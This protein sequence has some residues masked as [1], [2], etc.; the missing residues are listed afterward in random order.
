MVIL[1]TGTSS[2][3]GQGLAEALSNEHSVIPL[4]RAELD[5]SDI[6]KVKSF[7]M[8]VVDMLINCAGTDVGGKID[9][10]NH[11]TS[12]VVDIINVNFTSTVILTQLALKK[13]PDC[14]IIT[15]TSNC[16]KK[17][18]TN[19]LAYSLAKTSQELFGNLLELEY[20]KLN[21]L[22]VLIG[23][24]KTNFNYNRHMH[25]SCMERMED[26]YVRPHLTVEQVVTGIKN[27]MFDNSIKRIDIIP[28]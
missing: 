11:N 5:L 27:V 24:T 25:G 8:P 28:S 6:D 19:R 14:K 1:I 4:T 17:Y 23:L 21:Y 15:I 10:V 22:E 20:P 9:F 26:V 7:E 13:N 16:T 12:M 18:I 3:I 2:G